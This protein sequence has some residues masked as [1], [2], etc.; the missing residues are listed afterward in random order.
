MTPAPR[1]SG[2]SRRAPRAVHSGDRLAIVTVESPIPHD[3]WLYGFTR[4]HTDVLVRVHNVLVVPGGNTL[5]DFEVLGP[6]IGWSSEIARFPDVLEASRLDVPPDTGRYRVLYRESTIVRIM[7]E[8]GI[9]LRY[10]THA[11][12]GLLNF[13]TVDRISRIRRLLTVLRAAHLD[14]RIVSLR[15]E[16]LRTRQ[17]ILSQVQRD[18]FREALGA[19]YFEVPRRITLTRLAAQLSRSKSSVSRTVAVVEKKI[20]ETASAVFV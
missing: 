3:V 11:K 1:R 6:P 15:H 13:E 12:D 9:L 5:G 17:P 16:S 19:G 14:S 2:R 20:I 7:V 18:V 8:M 4:N 10:P